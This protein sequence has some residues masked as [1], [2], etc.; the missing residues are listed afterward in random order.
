[1]A[2]FPPALTKDPPVITIPIM[3]SDAGVIITG[4]LPL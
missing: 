4:G 1:M 3:V 2:G